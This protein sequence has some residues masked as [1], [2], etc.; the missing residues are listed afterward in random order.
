[1]TTLAQYRTS[2][3][4]APALT[5]LRRTGR[6]V[7]DLLAALVNSFDFARDMQSARTPA[8]R[9]AVLDRYSA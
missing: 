4:T 3:P 8:A 2:V 7:V 6:S 9:K 5:G 1:V